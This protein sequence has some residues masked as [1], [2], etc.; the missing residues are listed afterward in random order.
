M[1]NGVESA[2]SY[3]G[4]VFFWIS[5]FLRVAWACRIAVFGAILPSLV[6]IYAP[7]ARDLFWF[8]YSNIV[9]NGSV[10]DEIK[11]ATVTGLYWLLFFI[12]VT[13]TWSL[14]INDSARVVLSYPDW[15]QNQNG[16]SVADKQNLQ[17]TYRPIMIWFPRFLSF[18]PFF[19][20]SWSCCLAYRNLFVV[21]PVAEGERS[22]SY[23]I[24]ILTLVTSASSLLI[25]VLVIAY[26]SYFR[27]FRPAAPKNSIAGDISSVAGYRDAIGDPD[28]ITGRIKHVRRYFIVGTL[29]LI[30]TIVFPQFITKY[31]ALA[32]ILPIVAGTWIPFFTLLSVISNKWISIGGHRLR[33][34]ATFIFLAVVTSLAAWFGDNHDISRVAG[35]TSHQIPIT[36]A[37]ERWK[38][39]NCVPKEG[40]DRQCPRPMI[41]T[42]SGGASRAA[43]FEAT[44]LGE[45]L[46][47]SG[48]ASKSEGT[49]TGTPDARRVIDRIFAISGVSG[50]SLGA[51]MF[52]AAVA[53]SKNGQAPCRSDVTSPFLFRAS[54][55]R[56]YTNSPTRLKKWRY[57]LQEL[58]ADDFLSA[59]IIGL[60]FRDNF[61]FLNKISPWPDRASILENTWIESFRHW[62]K[63]TDDPI[64]GSF[65]GLDEAF[66]TFG[67]NGAPEGE[68]Q[69][70]LVL[71]GTS[72]ASGRRIVTSHIS[73]IWTF[74]EFGWRPQLNRVFRDAY[75]LYELLAGK[76]MC[77]GASCSII[78]EEIPDIT[79]ATA[80]TNSARFPIISPP[81]GIR[82]PRSGVIEDRIV[83]GGYFE[84]DGETTAIDLVKALG[85]EHLV[86]VVLHISN[87]PGR[88]LPIDEVK[89][90]DLIDWRH[91]AT[92]T[93][94]QNDSG[95]FAFLRGP[96]GALFATRSG[97][98][99]HI[100]T[101][102]DDDLRSIAD[103]KKVS[104]DSLLLQVLVS[105]QAM[106]DDGKPEP[107][108]Q[109]PGCWRAPELD[110]TAPLRE[111]SMSWWLAQSDQQ[112][113]DEQ[114]I[115]GT[116]CTA[117][118]AARYW[119]SMSPNV[120]ES[121]VEANKVVPER[122]SDHAEA[123]PH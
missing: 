32:L 46:D 111:V 55:E 11:E 25:G 82:D 47:S 1:I 33:V 69:P 26:L 42:A 77:N 123:T 115:L 63:P 94:D 50:G 30:I 58:V 116:N 104:I 117:L 67:P 106:G 98:A 54:P 81:G 61:N 15:L 113:L 59:S 4:A 60:A 24:E 66:S 108:K 92:P 10:S 57:C 91:A 101:L 7:Q 21:M 44:V 9:T 28:L 34:P 119:L 65:K 73:P 19:A 110:S 71:N 40:Q 43:F 118:T 88:L 68:W 75:D 62:V 90:T 41:I 12:L 27:K 95:W 112:Y 99:S 18:I 37:I 105:G 38:Q 45:L 100:V 114:L 48:E 74:S 107:D 51:V 80:A 16:T 6:L 29:L 20:I 36:A 22:A 3:L 96:L 78:R 93:D 14:P 53:N 2:K 13:L 121:Q 31:L 79:L 85:E 102:L 86:P 49:D 56:D 97:H 120:P 89:S 83:D 23:A 35:V 76:P 122:T 70:L 64:N 103:G 5:S 17:S 72:V 8:F 39:V 52:S 109:I 87:D 84:N